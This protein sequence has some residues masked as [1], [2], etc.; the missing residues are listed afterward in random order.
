LKN[1]HAYVLQVGQSYGPWQSS[2]SLLPPWY[3][4]LASGKNP[5][6]AILCQ[7]KAAQFENK[8]GRVLLK[9]PRGLGIPVARNS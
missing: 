5:T 1:Y 9:Q 2:Q 3:F 6:A 4:S 7:G 8:K